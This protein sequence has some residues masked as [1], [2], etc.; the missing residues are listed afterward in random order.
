VAVP[1]AVALLSLP[2]LFSGKFRRFNF[3][4]SRKRVA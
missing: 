2:L 4:I 1:F 3:R